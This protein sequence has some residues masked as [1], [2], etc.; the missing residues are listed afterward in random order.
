[1]DIH[2][3]YE[4]LISRQNNSQRWNAIVCDICIIYKYKFPEEELFNEEEIWDF[5]FTAR[6]NHL[7]YHKKIWDTFYREKY[8]EFF[9]VVYTAMDD[10]QSSWWKEITV[11]CRS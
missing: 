5:L 2:I 10:P 3:F 6:D 7:V 8:N 9:S 11:E 4:K 1:M